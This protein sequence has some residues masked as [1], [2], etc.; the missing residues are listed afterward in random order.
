MPK[1]KT[2]K[3]SAKRFRST[4]PKKKNA[5]KPKLMIRSGGQDHFNA[6]E[7]SKK[8]RNKR[9]DK[10]KANKKDIKNIKRLIPY[11]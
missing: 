3:A 7:S 1:L 4:N 5:K 9:A 6:N 8:T 11:A 10:P 2:H